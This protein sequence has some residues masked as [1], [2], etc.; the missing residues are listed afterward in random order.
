MTGLDPKLQAALVAR[1]GDRSAR[2]VPFTAGLTVEAYRSLPATL[3]EIWAGYGL[4][5]LANGRLRLLDPRRLASVISFIFEG[6]PDLDGDVHAIAYGNLGEIVLWSGWYGYGFLSPV[7]A[8]LEMPNLTRPLADPAEAQ[9][10]TQV[11]DM[12]P[13][14]LDA[15]DPARNPVHDRLVARLGPLPEG[16]IYGTTPVPPPLEGTPVEHY[17]IADAIE[18]LEAVYAEIAVTLVDWEMNPAEFRQIRQPWPQGAA[19][20]SQRTVQR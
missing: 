18:W 6:D 2:A 20:G 15:Y 19:P 9:F 1:L 12:P 14:V 17:V 5:T 4:V 16:A 7:L 8:T 3:R 11:L 10:I 13:E